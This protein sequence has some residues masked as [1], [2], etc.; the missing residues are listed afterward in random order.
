MSVCK[1]FGPMTSPLTDLRNV[2]PGPGPIVRVHKVLKGRVKYS[3]D[4][5]QTFLGDTLTS[6]FGF[7]YCF[8][9]LILSLFF[10]SIFCSLGLIFKFLSLTNHFK[11]FTFE[12]SLNNPKKA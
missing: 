1:G 6:L 3:K 4:V 5:L 10:G 8:C 12:K 11:Q 7:W 9:F 2:A